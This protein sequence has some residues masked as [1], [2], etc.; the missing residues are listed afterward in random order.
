L[1][2]KSIN[3][4]NKKTVTSLLIIF[5][6]VKELLANQISPMSSFS[7]R[8]G[9]KENNFMF[10]DHKSKFLFQFKKG[11]QQKNDDFDNFS[12][13]VDTTKKYFYKFKRISEIN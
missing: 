8:Y 2:W 4:K 12:F 11:F 1:S 7:S 5:L 3:L 9:P 6:N 10:G 13:H